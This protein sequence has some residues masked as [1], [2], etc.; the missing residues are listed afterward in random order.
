[1]SAEILEG[2]LEGALPIYERDIDA[3][4][5]WA[6]MQRREVDLKSD[7]SGGVYAKYG[8]CAPLLCSS[9]CGIATMG[10]ARA[11]RGRG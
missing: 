3:V 5:Y 4:K 10:N 6:G 7:G 2:A 8:W 11:L 9:F 1:M